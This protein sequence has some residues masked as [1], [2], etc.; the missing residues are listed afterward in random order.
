MIRGSVGASEDHGREAVKM[1]QIVEVVAT[2]I[3]PQVDGP[4]RAAAVVAAA[5]GARDDV[6]EEHDWKGLVLLS[7]RLAG[8]RL[9]GGGRHRRIVPDCMRW[10]NLSED[11]GEWLVRLL[12][13]MLPQWLWHRLG[14]LLHTMTSHG[15]NTGRY[16]CLIELFPH[17]CP[18]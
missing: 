14:L 9:L 4:T 2:A 11:C 13:H 6:G 3:E 12:R 10:W 5:A 17:D 8:D 7:G 15:H 18:V 16:L 1:Q